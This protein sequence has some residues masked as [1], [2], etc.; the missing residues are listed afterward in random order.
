MYRL[1]GTHLS[2]EEMMDHPM[3]EFA[4]LVGRLLAERWHREKGPGAGREK[5]TDYGGDPVAGDTDTGPH[6]ERDV[7]GP[8]S[9]Q[10][11]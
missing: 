11:D 1:D 10:D 4:R 2:E 9:R 8:G 7:G 6:E 5:G 3:E